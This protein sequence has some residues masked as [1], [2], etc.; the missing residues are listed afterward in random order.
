MATMATAAVGPTSLNHC[1]SIGVIII[2][3]SRSQEGGLVF[4]VSRFLILRCFRHWLRRVR[5]QPSQSEWRDEQRAFESA[6]FPSIRNGLRAYRVNELLG[7]VGRLLTPERLFPR[8]EIFLL[9]H[10]N[11]PSQSHSRGSVT[12]EVSASVEIEQHFPRVVSPLSRNKV[13]SF[14]H[15]C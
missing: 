1:I 2:P 6:V 15:L 7:N 12:A 11:I 9:A 4:H 8:R 3:S 13:A 10:Y 5:L 14:D